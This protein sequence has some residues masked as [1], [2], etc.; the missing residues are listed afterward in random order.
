MLMAHVP[1][2]GSRK[3]VDLWRWFLGCVSW[4]LDTAELRFTESTGRAKD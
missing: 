4:V 2:T 1:E 3:I